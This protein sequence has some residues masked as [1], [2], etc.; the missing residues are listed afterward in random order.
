M[1]KVV[2]SRLDSELPLGQEPKSSVISP[3]NTQ[4]ALNR[5]DFLRSPFGSLS[6]LL[7]WRTL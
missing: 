7:E 2:T 1:S 5:L 6:G 3:H 4:A